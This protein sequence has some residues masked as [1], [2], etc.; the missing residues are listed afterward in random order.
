MTQRVRIY[1]QAWS[2]LSSRFLA[3]DI[4]LIS[5]NPNVTWVISEC[6]ELELLDKNRVFM[7]EAICISRQLVIKTKTATFCESH[8]L[9]SKKSQG[10]SQT[11]RNKKST[12]PPRGKHTEPTRL[13]KFGG[14]TT[15][16]GGFFGNPK[17]MMAVSASESHYDLETQEFLE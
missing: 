15:W 1:H 10:K 5:F 16:V 11:F 13:I 2:S 3:S 6:K 12:S 9:H 7:K 4:H 17:H 8:Q 14:T